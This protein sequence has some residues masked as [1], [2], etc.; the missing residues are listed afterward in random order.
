MVSYENMEQDSLDSCMRLWNLYDQYTLEDRSDVVRKYGVPV[1]VYKNGL[2][3][4][5]ELSDIFV[6]VVNSRKRGV[7]VNSVTYMNDSNP[8]RRFLGGGIEYLAGRILYQTEESEEHDEEI[9][10]HKDVEI[11]LNRL[12]FPVYLSKPNNIGE[13]QLDPFFQL[14]CEIHFIDSESVENALFS[15]K[16]SYFFLPGRPYV[17]Q[18]SIRKERKR[19][20][21]T[22]DDD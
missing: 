5:R 13:I 19:I 22:I 4:E 12:S 16:Y 21:E 10:I 3:T 18:P 1:H 14:G 7:S 2:G 20:L 11:L 17:E 6:D 9:G 15:E 8:I